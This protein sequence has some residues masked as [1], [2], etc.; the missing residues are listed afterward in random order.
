[1]KQEKN[2]KT[3]LSDMTKYFFS[4]SVLMNIHTTHHIYKIALKKNG[5]ENNF[6]LRDFS[7]SAPKFEVSYPIVIRGFDHVTQTRPFSAG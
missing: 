5:F 4:K 6:F 7:S 3:H 2:A 1:V